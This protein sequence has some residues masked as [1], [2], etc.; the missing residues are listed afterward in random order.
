MW[1][2]MMNKKRGGNPVTFIL[3]FSGISE[4]RKRYV[5]QCIVLSLLAI[6]HLLLY[7]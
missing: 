4:E 3:G 5:G 2:R 7:P 6:Q 1:M